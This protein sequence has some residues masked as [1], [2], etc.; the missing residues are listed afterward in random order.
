MSKLKTGNNAIKK[1]YAKTVT[2]IKINK[3]YNK[4]QSK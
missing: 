3:F 4:Y 2:N 1:N